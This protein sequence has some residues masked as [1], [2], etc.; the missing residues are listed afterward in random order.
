LTRVVCDAWLLPSNERRTVAPYWLEQMPG[1]ARAAL[2]EH[3]ATNQRPED[4]GTDG[5]RRYKLPLS[6][7]A[8]RPWLVDV[9]GTPGTDPAWYAAGLRE[10][11]DAAASDVAGRAPMF[12]RSRPLLAVPLVGA[13][14]GGAKDIQGALVRAL[15]TELYRAVQE[16]EVDVALVTWT[17]AAF[18]AAQAERRRMGSVAWTALDEQ[19]REQADS[20]VAHSHRGNL[21]LFLGAGAS[22]GAGL[23]SWHELV[24]WLAADADLTE[25]EIR[26]LA[27]FNV[28]DQARLL[29]GR[30][31]VND[32]ELGERI[33]D[34]FQVEHSSLVH[35]LVAGL[36]VNEVVTTNYDVLFEQASAAVGR[37]ATV[38]P[39]GEATSSGRWLLKLHGTIECPEDI[40][41]TREDFL[42]YSDR[43]QA[44]A[45]IVQAMLM[46]RHMLFVGFSLRDDNFLRIADDVRKVVRRSDEEREPFAT[47]LLIEDDV[48]MRELWEGDVNCVSVG[49]PR[50]VEILLD[51]LLAES[52][53]GAS[54]LLTPE[55]EA[56]LSAA[57]GALRDALLEFKRTVPGDVRAD[58]VWEPVAALLRS[59]GDQSP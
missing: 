41:L 16:H 37:P 3:L 50:S 47:A 6:E 32:V 54:Y 10:F 38:V 31:R 8:P 23:P 2:E 51:Y 26:A 40:V 34:R 44:L 46:T 48:L 1:V 24:Q 39:Y 9:G 28:L 19:V 55:F 30:L 20:L 57:E 17:Q 42:R 25:N 52:S 11:L 14:M 21:V 27:Q 18:A 33:A 36:P 58:P 15:L 45:G 29:A 35:A 59:L 53:T 13:G 12:G 49:S 7:P 4:W 43:R 22:I 56:L 5:S